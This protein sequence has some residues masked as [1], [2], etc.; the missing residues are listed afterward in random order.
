MPFV[1][2]ASETKHMLYITELS[3][4]NV[5]FVL[6]QIE[7]WLDELTGL[8]GPVNVLSDTTIHGNLTVTGKMTTANGRIRHA[9]TAITEPIAS[10]G[11]ARY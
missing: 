8:H 11:C 2:P 7:D 1:R 4:D 6:K 9:C 5:N 3:L 10:L